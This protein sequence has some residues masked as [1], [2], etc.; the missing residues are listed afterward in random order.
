MLW[1][2]IVKVQVLILYTNMDRYFFTDGMTTYGTLVLL[3]PASDRFWP[4][5]L[6]IFL[7]EN[8]FAM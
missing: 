8:L 5:L 1:I 2:A 6:K 4:I 7:A 3:H